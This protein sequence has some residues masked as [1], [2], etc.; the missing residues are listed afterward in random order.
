MER[1]IWIV[2]E[3]RNNILDA[4]RK[5]NAYGGM[6]AMCIVSVEFMKQVIEER[7]DKDKNSTSN[8][9]LILIGDNI[10]EKNDEVISVLKMHP[11]LASVP[12]FFSTDKIE[13]SK[14]EE[15]YLKG[16]MMVVE[17]PLNKSALLKMYNAS[18]QYELSKNYE[19]ILQKQI[20]ELE[21]A[22]AIKNLNTQL[23]SRNEFLY[24]IFGKY[25]S[26]EL[27]DIILNKQEG[28]LIGGEKIEIAV[29]FS[30]L[31]GFTSMSEGL[32]PE[33]I[34]DLLNCYFGAMSEVIM[35]YGGTIIEFLGDGILAV[36]GAPAKNEKYCANAIAAAIGM[37]NA[38]QKVNEYCN[39]NGFDE[40][41][42][43]V[44]IH[45]GESF[46]G[47]VGTEQMMRY[48]V[49]GSVVNTCSR[50]ESYSVGGQVLASEIIVKKACEKVFFDDVIELKAKGL[51]KPLNVCV[52]SGIG[53]K[54]NCYLERVRKKAVYTIDEEINIEIFSMTNKIVTEFGE[55]GKLKEYSRNIIRLEMDK[56]HQFEAYMDV[57]LRCSGTEQGQLG[58]F[59]DVYGKITEVQGKDL[60]LN[61]T[62]ITDEYKEFGKSVEDGKVRLKL[63]WRV[64]MKNR[65]DVYVVRCTAE[66]LKYGKS[67]F[68][69]LNKKFVLAFFENDEEANVYFYSKDKSIR[70]MEFMDFLTE[71]YSTVK[72]DGVIASAVISK[73]FL[74]VLMSEYETSDLI[75]FFEKKVD[76]YYNKCSWI[77]A[78]EYI[79][80]NA[81]S[82][83]QLPL[84]RKKSVAWAYVKT[85]DIVPEGK[86]FRMKSLENETDM[87][88][89]SS[90]DLYIM[91]GCRGEIYNISEAKFVSTYEKSDE[92][93]DIFSQM[94]DYIPE[95]QLDE[96][97]EY[98]S[99]D[100]KAHLCY[101]KDDKK[102]YAVPIDTRTKVFSEHNKGEYFVG[103]AGDYMAIREDDF[104]DIYIIQREIFAQTYEE[105]K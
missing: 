66:D 94:P 14:E 87:I 9:S 30:D 97:D 16:A 45:C 95:V 49:I 23:E 38:M 72:G 54:Y 56:E 46:V 79:K 12:M 82:I 91:I 44:G 18:W 80:D 71:K 69:N 51:K 81:D 57:R 7:I 34:T 100:D 8:P 6:K 32:G 48:N 37:Q 93:F 60:I 20:S 42:M 74:N 55:V 103:T 104:S 35:E 58:G 78:S 26:D 70:S 90:P 41:Q 2:E 105:V 89:V 96:N 99:L 68:E 3:D 25:F 76:E 63:E 13:T 86:K 39:N 83:E 61:L 73:L 53:G 92:E 33:A 52:L 98:I 40:L 29:L 75:T 27:L 21:S 36:F 64:E 85:S 19:R 88:F 77:F 1:I 15:Y 31:R 43:G 17:K 84:Y 28:Q 10:I 67:F 62:R 47:N 59:A 4:Q 50:I 24:R 102:I 5:I 101:P 11:K 22:K 65:E